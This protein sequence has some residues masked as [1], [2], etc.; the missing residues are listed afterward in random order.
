MKKWF[1]FIVMFSFA[2]SLFAQSEYYWYR[3]KKIALET[4]PGKKFVL[5]DSSEDTVSFKNGLQYGNRN[6]QMKQLQKLELTG[7]RLFNP[8]AKEKFWTI[9][10]EKAKK[11]SVSDNE[12]NLYEAPFFLINGKTEISLSHL[13]YVKLYED[14]DFEKLE[15]LAAK[16]HVEI[17]GNNEFMPLW[18]TL[19]CTRE[20]LGN[21]LEMANIFCES[22]QFAAAEPDFSGGYYLDCKND[23]LFNYQWGLNNTGQYE[24]YSGFDRPDVNLCEAHLITK[25]SANVIIAL[26][27]QGV[28][29]H[30]DLP[31]IYSKSFDGYF[32]PNISNPHPN[33]V[34]GNHGTRCAGI[35]SAK[36]NNNRGVAGIAPDCPLMSVSWPFN[37]VP[38]PTEPS[39]VPNENQQIA[40][41]INWAW[42][43]GASVISNSWGTTI[44]SEVLDD[45][46]DSALTC[47]RNGLGCVVVFSTG[48]LYGKGMDTVAYPACYRA[49]I[50]TVGAMTPKFGGK[51]S[52]FSQCGE[53]LDVV[54]PGEYV[55]TT[56]I[57]REY[58]L[59]FAGTSAACPHVAAIA[60]LILSVRPNLT[61]RQVSDIIEV[62][63]QKLDIYEM[64]YATVAGRPNGIWESEAGY[65]LVDA[66]AAVLA[67]QCNTTDYVNKTITTNTTLYDCEVNMQNIDIQNNAKLS[68]G[69]Q[70]EANIKGTFDMQNGTQFELKY[71]WKVPGTN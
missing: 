7:I 15:N 40:N 64:E 30:P 25:G 32:S 52:D 13:F 37:D 17:L 57:D 65:G 10:E 26:V 42:H 61:A 2:V 14:T 9:V 38:R 56:T 68:V 66:Y 4:L 47:G 39:P 46:L 58:Q 33:Y 67:A 11:S 18:Y 35:I 8:S 27:D 71:E 3:G 70:E 20:S 69:I 1:V 54:A 63:A 29:L 6:A 51:R 36:T 16:Y 34:W 44:Q 21:A 19:S 49:E 62:T 5:F 24:D 59:D 48:N 31:D 60:G 53:K 55:P 22:G 45:A 28:E 12:K 23:S 43:N 50:I 41:C